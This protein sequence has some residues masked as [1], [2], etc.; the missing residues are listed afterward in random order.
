MF[1]FFK[2]WLD[3]FLITPQF[4]WRINPFLG[5]IWVLFIGWTWLISINISRISLSNKLVTK[6]RRPSLCFLFFKI[7]IFYLIRLVRSLG[8][9]WVYFQLMLLWIIVRWILIHSPFLCIYFTN[10]SSILVIALISSEVILWLLSLCFLC[11]FLQ[12]F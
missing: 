8:V 3:V 5:R 7:C 6:T 11:R 1:L 4:V 9:V 10:H 2:G 12:C